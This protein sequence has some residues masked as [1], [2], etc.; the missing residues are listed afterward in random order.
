MPLELKDTIDGMCSNDYKERFVA[1][2]V[3]TKVRYNK[4]RKFIGRVKY[5]EY[6]DQ[7]P[8]KHDCPIDLLE[9]QLFTMGLYLA[10]L[11]TRAKQYE[12]IKLPEVED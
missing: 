3:Q 1:E 7:E 11:E 6:A 12:E 9:K 8:P 5:A 10:I 2:Y 4:L